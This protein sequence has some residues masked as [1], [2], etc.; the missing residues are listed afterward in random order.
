MSIYSDHKVGALSDDEFREECA[1]ENRIDR[2][3]REYID[4]FERL[5]DEEFDEDE[6]PPVECGG[7][8]NGC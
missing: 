6:Q 2:A 3:E 8:E 4:D 5:A 1:R 7:G